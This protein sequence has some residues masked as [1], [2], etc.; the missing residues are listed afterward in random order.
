MAIRSMQTCINASIDEHNMNNGTMKRCNKC[1]EIKD[2]NMFNKRKGAKDGHRGQ[3]KACRKEYYKEYHENNKDMIKEYQKEYHENNKDMIKEYQK[4]Y[5]ENNKDKIKES[6][7]EYRENNKDKIKESKKEYYENNKDMIK[8]YYENNKDMIKEYK[9]E[10]CKTHKIEYKA[11]SHKRRA[12]IK[13]NGGSYTKAEW[14]ECLEFFDYKCAYSGEPLTMDDA[15]VEHVI[16]V[17]KGGTSY[18]SN[19]IPCVLKYNISKNNTDLMGWYVE[20]PFYNKDRLNKIYAWM[21]IQE[22]L[23]QMQEVV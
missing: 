11:Y 13:S 17:S 12:R 7:K 14:L 23:E 22:E 2:I 18:I 5:H 21:D 8:E 20:Q 4:E 1:G 6:K 10:Y 9:K 16:P 19:L 15:S 3:C